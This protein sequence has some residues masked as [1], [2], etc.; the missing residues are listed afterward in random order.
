M[1]QLA[2]LGS[3]GSI[4][5]NTLRVVE[6]L[7]GA[8]GIAALGAG[9]NVEVLAEQIVRHQPRLVSV[10]DEASAEK[11]RYELSQRNV[12][13]LPQISI[14]VD[15][16]IEVAT[17]VEAEIVV[18][19]VV[20][21]LG[22]LPTYRA[23]ELGKRVAL[24]NK[25][26]LVIAG[27]LMTKAAAKS[28]AELLPVDSEHNALHQCLRGEKRAEL[29]RLILTASGGPF[30]TASKGEIENATRAQALK[31][32]TW[33]MGAK[34]TID[35]A[36]LMNKGLEVIEARWLF[37][38]SADEIDIVVHP[39]SVVHSLVEMV[40]GSIIAQLGVTDMRHAIQYALTYPARHPADLPPLDLMALSKLEFFAPDP[41]KFPCLRLAYQALR[42]GGTMPAVLNAA[43][44]IAV[45][46]FL[47]ERIRFGDIPRL[48]EAACNA[49][50]LQPAVDL[51]TVL[52]ADQW[53][54]DWVTQ[55]IGLQSGGQA[56][57]AVRA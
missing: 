4:G 44:E 11:L 50:T 54:R 34:I 39:Q 40:D 42:A 52:A 23:L 17:C 8:F 6:A 37:Q 10:S 9:S 51:E 48:I 41:D 53:A 18:G 31:H 35:S 46:A 14:G 26:T 32:P 43:N 19:A 25:E 7:N 47:A 5:C 21:A 22:L 15:G 56:S 30:R 45:A 55:Q 38:C 12:T 2:I 49:H 1:K 28:G 36:T 13:R 27:E 24:A 20:G 3:T 16:L 29:K 33:Q 57:S